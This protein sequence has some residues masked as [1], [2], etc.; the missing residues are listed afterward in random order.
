[1]I[2]NQ[3]TFWFIHIEP[4]VQNIWKPVKN[5]PFSTKV[6]ILFFVISLFSS[7]SCLCI[8][9]H[10]IAH[11]QAVCSTANKKI[12]KFNLIAYAIIKI[13]VMYGV[14]I[15]IKVWIITFKGKKSLISLQNNNKFQFK[16]NWVKHLQYYWSEGLRT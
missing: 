3:F 7:D 12:S 6:K 4:Q 13:T 11:K 15:I 9:R 14:I 10:L 1:M 16:T 2:N 8:A 5:K